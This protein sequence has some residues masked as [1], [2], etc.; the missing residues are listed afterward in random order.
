MMQ[1]KLVTPG[2]K[3]RVIEFTPS[4]EYELYSHLDDEGETSKENG[5]TGMTMYE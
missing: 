2:N 3:P 5:N 1:R 4:D